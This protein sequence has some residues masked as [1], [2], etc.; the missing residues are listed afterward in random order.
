MNVNTQEDAGQSTRIIALA[1]PRVRFQNGG[2]HLRHAGN[3]VD[4][5]RLAVPCTSTASDAQHRQSGLPRKDQQKHNESA[6]TIGLFRTQIRNTF[7]VAQGQ[8]AGV[9]LGRMMTALEE[10][11][12]LEQTADASNQELLLALAREFTSES[13]GRLKTFLEENKTPEQTTDVSNQELFLALA[14]ELG[15]KLGTLRDSLLDTSN[16]FVAFYW[17][18]LGVTR[19]M[20]SA[21]KAT[22]VWEIVRH[23]FA[24][25]LK[26][27]EDV[28]I[29]EIPEIPEIHDLAGVF[30]YLRKVL[31]DLAA[32]AEQEYRSYKETAFLLRSPENAKWL[33]ESIE[34]ANKGKIARYSSVEEFIK[35]NRGKVPD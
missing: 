18:A 17:Y 31:R 6:K 8:A 22:E 12:E 10:I 2:G 21:E 24:T 9:S 14:R 34:Q 19:E 13:L 3:N 25:R 7:G 5:I 28:A 4:I 20:K 1:G 16:K 30:D 35:S 23:L 15:S 32:K 29:P 11:K 26:A 27:W 33:N